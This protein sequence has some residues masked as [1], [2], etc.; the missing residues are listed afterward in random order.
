MY[1]GMSRNLAVSGGCRQIFFVKIEKEVAI[2]ETICYNNKAAE[3]TD[4][5]LSW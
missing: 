2:Q 3:I 4:S 5:L 1:K